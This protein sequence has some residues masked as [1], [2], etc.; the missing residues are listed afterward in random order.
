M[1]RPAKKATPWTACLAVRYLPKNQERVV[2][3]TMSRSA[4]S[5]SVRDSFV[6]SKSESL[7]ISESAIAEGEGFWSAG[8]RGRRARKDAVGMGVCEAAVVGWG[9]ECA[10]GCWTHFEIF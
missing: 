4:Q 8:W 6:G 1:E 9:G 3:G 7:E 2:G 10:G 5:R